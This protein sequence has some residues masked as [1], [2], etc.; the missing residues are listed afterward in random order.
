LPQ[1]VF[2]LDHEEEVESEAFL[3]GPNGEGFD[4]HAG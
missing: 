4:R 3:A 2:A 1:R